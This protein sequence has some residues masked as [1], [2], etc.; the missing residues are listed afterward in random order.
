MW[1]KRGEGGRGWR[2]T[3]RRE[4]KNGK[5]EGI[6]AKVVWRGKEK[7]GDWLMLGDW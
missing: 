6:L 2:T 4:K 7:K 3:I 1:E 5:W